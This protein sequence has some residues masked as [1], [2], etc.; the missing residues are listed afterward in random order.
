M[1]LRRLE[2]LQWLGLI[3]GGV[4]WFAAH[5]T[6][7][8]ITEAACDSA[9]FG[10]DHDLWQAIALGIAIALVLGA[11]AAALAVLFATRDVSYED[12]PAPGRI[13]FFAIAAVVANVLFLM[14]IVLAALA[15]IANPACT[16]A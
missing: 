9:N 2:V 14:I 15:S 10:L 1:T 3:L 13:R 16:Q 5:V 12:A 8:G 11:G 4:V 7:W 6:G